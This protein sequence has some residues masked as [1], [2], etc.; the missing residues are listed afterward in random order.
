MARDSTAWLNGRWV[1]P[2]EAAISPFDRGFLFGDAVYEVVPVVDGVPLLLDNHLHRLEDSLAAAAIRNPHTAAEWRAIVTGLLE[3]NGPD[4]QA[5]YLQVSRGTD[6]TRS[7]AIDPDL[8]PTVF[9]IALDIGAGTDKGVS[10]VVLNDDRWLHC[11]I[12][13]TSMLANVLLEKQAAERG[14]DEAILVRDGVLTEGTSCSVIVV[15]NGTLLT[16]ANGPELLPGTTVQ[17]VLQLATDA[18]IPWREDMVSEARLRAA[19]E[20]WLMSATRDIV[21][22]V[23]LDGAPVGNG[24]PGPLWAILAGRFA[25]WK[26]R[27]IMAAKQ[28]AAS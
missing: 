2:G 3:R 20:I 25:E 11:D 17:R 1:A 13:S 19:D 14:A 22:V 5:V 26:Q 10:A 7:R 9:A 24:E 18:D 6:R 16:R 8:T 15:E 28:S 12:K 21:P 4:T 23:T 27:Q